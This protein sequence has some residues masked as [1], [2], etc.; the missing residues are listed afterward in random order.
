[1]G[2]LALGL[3]MLALAS[4][5]GAESWG[6][7]TPGQSTRVDVERIFGRPSRERTLVE[8][9]RTVAEWTYAGER[10]PQGMERMVVSYGFLVGG[11]FVPDVVRA[12]TLYPKPRVFSLRSITNGWGMP[13]TIGTQE[14]TG[15]QSFHYRTR[16]LFIIFDKTVS[17]AELLLFGPPEPGGS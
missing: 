1:V 4:G 10:A 6:G 12:V 11:R 15:Q 7:L 5:V 3:A 13:D 16:G 2:R 17:W 8:E 9:G 14:A